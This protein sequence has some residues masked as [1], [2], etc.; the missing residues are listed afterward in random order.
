MNSKNRPRHIF[1]F[2]AIPLLLGVLSLALTL[3]S[4]SD[5]SGV[6]GPVEM[7]FWDIVTYEGSPSGGGSTFPFQQVDDSPLITLTSTSSLKD[8]KEGER[9]AVRYIPESG[10]A[11]TSGA[12]RLLSAS[13]ITQSPV[14]IEWK[15]EY[16]EWKRDKVYVYS[17]W[18]SGNYINFHVRLTY[19]TEP[20][21]FRLVADPSTIE[22]DIP[23]IYLVHIMAKETDYHDRAYLASFDIGELWTR[24]NL[25]GVRIHVANSNLDKDIFT[26]TKNN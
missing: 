10:Q 25:R 3:P 1:S 14:E 17:V 8:V 7:Q 21:L 13:K 9:M 16:D 4:C 15:E 23:D 19:D 26:F 2:S 5:D 12:I 22:S 18:R 20:R 11:Y 24:Q 6:D